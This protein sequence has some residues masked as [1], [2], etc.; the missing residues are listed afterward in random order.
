MSLSS[1]YAFSEINDHIV[2]TRVAESDA[3]D[4]DTFKPEFLIVGNFFVLANE[5]DELFSSIASAVEESVQQLSG[6]PLSTKVLIDRQTHGSDADG[7]SINV[8]SSD[9]EIIG[10]TLDV[11]R[12]RVDESDDPI[13]ELGDQK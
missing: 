4:A 3:R 1:L 8:G 9:V 13:V 12:Q 10:E 2:P 11:G 7:I 5:R 6:D